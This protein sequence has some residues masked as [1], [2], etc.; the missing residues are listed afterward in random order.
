[1]LGVTCLTKML[2][3]NKIRENPNEVK[4]GIKKKG[5]DPNLVDQF[6]DVDLRWR[7]M[8]KKLDG[9]RANINILSK[10]RNIEKA[11]EVKAV[12]KKL[13]GEI[14]EIEENRNQIILEFP[15]LPFS[16]WPAGKNEKDN[17]VLREVGEKPN[18][19]FEPKDYL[20]ENLG[21]IDIERAS[22]VAGSRFGYLLGGAAM[23]ELALIQYTFA[24]LIPEGFTA[25]IPPVMARAEIM[26]GMGKGKFIK[27]KDAFYLPDDKLYLVGSAEHTMGPLHMNEV[28]K[29]DELPKRYLG[30]STSF[31]RE[32]GSYGRDT[33]GIL[34]VH[35]FTKIEM[36]SFVSPDNSVNEHEFFLKKEEELVSGLGLPYQVVQVCT[37]DMTWGDA[38][39]YDI[40]TW[41]PGESRYRETH[42]TSNT[43]DYQ[44]R[45]MNIRFEAEDGTKQF[46]HMLN[47]TAFGINRIII[48]IIENYQQKD[49]SIKIPEALVPY[50]GM[51][52]I[53]ND[54]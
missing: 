19:D 39:Q 50:M 45:G 31:R 44:A 34:R 24:K 36:F 5:V 8:R 52:L 38:A 46:V 53:R 1:M 35:Q 40:E 30:V 3:I 13:E 16:D 47:G 21:I 12:I 49:G 29:R 28:L 25:V 2:D 10:E 48:A 23:L 20:A 41:M 54:D 15:N 18:F 32:A 27:E 43:T 7:E 6:L 37:G 14:K 17:V 11:K 33:K 9:E 42:S 51:D 26:I 22:R 4:E